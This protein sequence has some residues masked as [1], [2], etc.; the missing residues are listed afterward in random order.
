MAKPSDKAIQ[1]LVS[2]EPLL[3]SRAVKAILEATVPENLRGFNY[4]V[5]EAKAAGA[6]G[7]LSAAKT[8]PMMAEKRMVLVRGFNALAAAELA[9]MVSYLDDPN[10]STVLVLLATK[11]DGRIK[12]FSKAKK[13]GYLNSLT[14][15]RNANSWLGAEIRDQ[16]ANMT[17]GAQRRLLEVIGNDLSRL[18]LSIEQLRLFAGDRAVTA[19]DVDELIAETRER[20]VFELTDAIGAGDVLWTERAV[21]AMIEQRQSAIGVVVMLARFMRQLLHCQEGLA[22]NLSR[23]DIGKRAGVPPFIVEKLIDQARGFPRGQLPKAFGILAKADVELKGKAPAT[24]IL[25]KLDGDGIIL[26]SLARDLLS[27]RSLK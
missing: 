15:P 1:I 2:E 26:S 25:G 19:D 21:S 4:D 23:S 6:T 24:K 3:L 16:G 8:L 11:I 14:V 12:F 20:T 9:K 27:L 13:L 17:S 7:I 5:F 10:P 22:A 18:S